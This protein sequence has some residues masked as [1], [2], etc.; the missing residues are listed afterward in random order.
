[1]RIERVSGH[2]F[3][4]DVLGPDSIV[5]DLGVNRGSFAFAVADA[6]GCRVYGVEPDER[7][8]AGLPPKR[9]VIVERAAVSGSSGVVPMF[10]EAGRDPTVVPDLVV[11]EAEREQVPAITLQALLARH[12]I[13][14]VDLL[15]VDVEGA[16]IE[17]LLAAPADVLARVKQVTVEFHDWLSPLLR[18]GTTRVDGRLRSLGFQRLAFSRDT[19]DV[20]YVSAETLPLGHWRRLFLL[21]RFKYVRGARR[22]ATRRLRGN[23]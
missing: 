20:L 22:R 12:G 16:E 19:S 7:V 23:A 15:K 1:M 4:P 11:A 3:I 17:T 9:G 21:L 6:F 13:E 14:Q 5:V 2:S 10:R 8:L 18:D